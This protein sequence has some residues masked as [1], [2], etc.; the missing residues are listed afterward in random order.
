L[1]DTTSTL[2]Q[3]NDYV[4]KECLLC[5]PLLLNLLQLLLNAG[6]SF[7]LAQL[8]HLVLL[9]LVVAGLLHSW[10]G[11]GVCTDCVVSLSVDL[12]K[13]V[14]GDVT[15]DVLG[16]L[17]FVLFLIVFL[18]SG[19]VLSNVSRTYDTNIDWNRER[20]DAIGKG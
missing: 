16:E 3:H 9:R 20:K 4:V 19:H 13:D 8:G 10:T 17:T 12:L 2:S 5:H 15:V 6:L 11:R 7:L 1:N 14:G 18:E